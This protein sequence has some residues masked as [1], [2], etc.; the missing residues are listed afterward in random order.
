MGKLIKNHWAR[1]IVLTAAICRFSSSNPHILSEKMRKEKHILTKP[2]SNSSRHRRILLAQNLLGLPHQKPRHRREAAPHPPN[3]Q[4]TLWLRHVS[5]G[6]AARFHRWNGH[7]SQH[8]GKTRR[9]AYGGPGC[10][11]AVSSYQPRSLLCDWVGCIF[12][13]L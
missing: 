3:H 11:A 6:M 10:R 4:P 8:R 5:L 13:G 7:A 2:R 12:L 1:L 9:A